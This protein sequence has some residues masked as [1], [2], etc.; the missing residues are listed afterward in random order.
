MTLSQNEMPC[1]MCELLI[2]VENGPKSSLTNLGSFAGDTFH[3]N[4]HHT[5]LHESLSV[6][7]SAMLR[8]QPPVPNILPSQTSLSRKNNDFCVITLTELHSVLVQ[9][10]L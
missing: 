2:V 3:Y 8:K 5:S 9:I 1:T 6:E 4:N 7:V 10:L